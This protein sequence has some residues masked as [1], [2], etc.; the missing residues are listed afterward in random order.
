MLGRGYDAWGSWGAR[1]YVQVIPNVTGVH[2][3]SEMLDKCSPLATKEQEKIV[4]NIFQRS[5]N[6]PKAY[7]K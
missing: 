3:W 2:S 6:L 1:P 4:K 5:S 7:G